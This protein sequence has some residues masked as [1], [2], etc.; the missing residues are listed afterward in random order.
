MTP[1]VPSPD[2]MRLSA[3]KSRGTSRAL[4]P[5]T[6]WGGPAGNPRLQPPPLGDPAP[7]VADQMAQRRPQ[8]Q[9]VHARAPDGAGEAEQHRARTRQRPHPREPLAADRK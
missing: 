9:L 7:D 3:S 2:P 1:A 8:R 4:S 6:A 5:R